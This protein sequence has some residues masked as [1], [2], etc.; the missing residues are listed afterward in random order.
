MSF[1]SRVTNRP[2]A[3]LGNGPSL[4]GFDF[5]TELSGF[6]TFGLNAAYRYW[7]SIGWYPTYY[8]CL[9]TVV[10]ASHKNAIARLI[11]RSEEYGIRA[12]LLREEVLQLLGTL[13]ALPHVK[14]LESLQNEASL[15]FKSRRITT[16]SHTLLWA[17]YLGYK[18][19]ALYGVD[20]NYVE[21]LPE[22]VPTGGA[23]L[24]I[25]ETP[26]HNPNYFFDNY[27]QA[28]DEYHI[29]NTGKEKG[30]LVHVAAWETIA[31]ALNS[32][33]VV[34]INASPDS[35]VETF[36]RCQHAEVLSVL[37]K[38]REKRININYLRA[39]PREA[40]V[41]CDELKIFYPFLPKQDGVMIDV[42]A[43][44]GWSCLR[45]LRRGWEVHAFEPDPSMREILQRKTLNAGNIHI[46]SRAVSKVSGREYPWFTTP[47]STGASSMRPFC[48]SHK[49]TGTVQTVTLADIIAER[50]ITH[51]DLLKI[52]TEG[53]DYMVL[54]GFPFHQLRPKHIICEYEDSKTLPLGNS[55][56]DI[57]SL[58][59]RH[60]YSVF[61]SEWHPIVRYGV[62]H[63]WHCFLPYPTPL[64]NST[65]WG[66]LLAFSQPP[67][68]ESLR[69]AMATAI[70]V[71]AAPP[72]Q[73]STEVS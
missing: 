66:N 4:R 72:P 64:Y 71:G 10:G 62:Q 31:P 15:V 70:L 9:D 20:A 34:V 36:P 63:Q 12:F 35:R 18:D 61:I 32:L 33:D 49:Q 7:D 25:N 40:G 73:S 13:I 29:P 5:V 52:D 59:L 26:K 54:Q 55:T 1:E 19:I 24:T 3:I 67:D 43:H 58:L 41:H 46:D 48:D 16:G 22:A 30:D 21:I 68:L 53:F 39:Y 56:H 28:G 6:D 2:A 65:S 23:R 38:E 45:F 14:S 8:A 60:E 42:G 27:Q 11:E 69:Q 50:N 57:A 17:A 51:I 47:E 44:A 37:R